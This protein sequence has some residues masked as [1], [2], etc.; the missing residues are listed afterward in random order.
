VIGQTISHYRIL[1]KLG[2]GGMGV[3]YKAEDVTLQRFVA[4]KFLPD[5]V[6]KDAQAL[7]RFQREAQAASAL[8]H[9]N[10]CTIY[11]IGEQ[12]GQPFIVMEFL[13]GLT[14]KHQIGGRPIETGVLLSLAIEIADG[15]DAAHAQGIVH[16][17]I[18][19]ANIFVTKRGHAKILDFGLAK[20]APPHSSS[21]SIAALN[22][23]SGSVGAE[24]LTSPG[25]MLGTVA[26]MSPEQVRAREL[27]ARSDLFSFGAVLYE[28]A[29][30]TLPFRGESSGMILDSILNKPPLPT[31]RL[32]PDLPVN[33]ERV[34]NKC[35][36]K[37]RNLRYQHASEIRVDMQ[38]LKRD[39]ESASGAG[40]T[41]TVIKP[42]LEAE[43][44]AV[45]AYILP[46]D[47]CVFLST[48]PN[49]G[50]VVVSPNGR[51]LVFA[52]RQ[53]AST[54]L[55]IR[56]I[57]S[58]LAQPLAGTEGASFPFWS[59]DSRRVGFF[60]D[61]KLKTI[62]ASGG[63]AQTVCDAPTGRGGSWSRD[64]VIAFAPTPT[65]PIYRVAAAGGPYSPVT[66]LDR[67][68]ATTHRWPHFLPDGRHFL[69]FGGHPL[70]NGAIYAGS[71]DGTE[72]KLIL[73]SYW[74]AVYAPPG[75]LL[76]VRDGTLVRRAYDTQ[77]NET[78]GD[79]VPI[80]EGVMS[81]GW[82]HRGIFSVSETGVLVYGRGAV[83]T[84]PRLTWFHRSGKQ[85]GVLADAASY[86]LH[87]LSPDGRRLAVA[88][89]LGGGATI[90]I[91]DLVRGS[92]T[93]LTFD[94]STNE[95]PL[96]SPDGSRIVFSSNR[97][98]LFHIYQKSSDGVGEEELIFESGADE[99]ALS[100]SPD[101]RF[102]A[103]LRREAEGSSTSNIWILPLTGHRKP[104]PLIESDCDK[105][106]PAFSPDGRW[107]AYVSNESGGPEIYVTPFPSAKGKWQIS[108]TGG[109]FPRW[110][111]D[112]K[113]LFYL[114]PD[115][116]VR[117]T[118]L[119]AR[120][121]SVKIGSTETVF[122]VQAVPPP[123][124][125]FDV[126]ADGKRFLI[127]TMPAT[128]G[129]TEPITLVIN[130]LMRQND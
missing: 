90:W 73:H 49:A 3:V 31:A 56:P 91:L 119:S 115:N 4:L 85:G 27:D 125:P 54:R 30:G 88:D 23:Q 93:R 63:P 81:D 67:V 108:T 6:A 121:S 47:K 16:R 62:E 42:R 50:P 68:Q 122:Q 12:T 82:V 94:P 33:F 126:T 114:G 103:Y 61:G 28:M 40:V 86:P 89:R 70:S 2:G 76:F 98:G 66:T 7:A 129:D 37:D 41:Q 36:E 78:H 80:A 107:M 55:F 123:A 1:E 5:E 52:A 116:R 71:L 111:G 22:T 92:K 26:Y 75:F 101:G 34:I 106:F 77:R 59:P 48:G 105:S 29:T 25:T 113:E 96:W 79:D 87:R 69:Y 120:G 58:L 127:N 124:T 32:N 97:K 10:I 84:G 11:E 109:T 43:I 110:R 21:S 39:T 20:V 46:P 17:D 24:H 99:H 64:D 15:L 74:N 72:R 65:S 95:L 53:P 9:P 83:A 19:P 18:K 118:A 45:R 14:L 104:F 60:A 112:G 57:E 102:L 117:A 128:Q 35:L 130:W 100:W 13:D 8:N 44:G 51:R 38:R